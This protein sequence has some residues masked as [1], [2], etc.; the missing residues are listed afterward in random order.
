MRA[1]RLR[2]GAVSLPTHPRVVV[3]RGHQATP[4]ELAPWER[5]EGFD[6]AVLQSR[7]NGWDLEGIGL[8]S[9]EARTALD[10]LPR[11][12]AG[13]VPGLLGDRYRGLDAALE[14]ADVV[15]VEELS[16]WFSADVARLRSRGAP[17]KLVATAWETIPFLDAYRTRPARGRRRTVL[18]A[19]D[20]FLATTRRAA[21]ALRLE[22]V[23][24]TRIEVAPPG[25]D[26]E[27]FA[28]PRAPRVPPLI[29]SPG[30]LVWEKGHQDVLRAAALLHGGEIA[31]KA[32]PDVRIVGAGPEAGRLRSHAD[33][34]G[35]GAHVEIGG[36][37]YR[38]MPAAFAEASALALMSLPLAGGGLHPGD[39]PRVFW[40]E[41]FGM[42]F[43]EALAA[44][45][46]IVA[47]DSGA[48]REVLGDAATFV[49]PGD[50][51]GLAE[52]LAGGVPA[53][54]ADVAG[55]LVE[56]Y[57]LPAAAQRLAAAYRRVLS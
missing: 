6:V 38:D 56:R 48:I 19:V 9:V 21:D 12:L 52:V 46:P 27:R 22:G 4:W 24:P 16:Y 23:D 26:A 49:A 25:I 1:R 5:L 7:L 42:V 2:F 55:E 39:V 54:P 45:L 43:A 57:S 30:R 14:G 44:G 47:A 8:E 3:V 32:P 36:A 13:R 18:G 34:L 35:I 10:R 41:Q 37:A 40:E 50:W 31:C 28:V 15:H 53:P 11:A 51:R 20:L 17:F 33:E 29:V